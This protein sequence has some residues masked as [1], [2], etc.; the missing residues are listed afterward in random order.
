MT[1]PHP[2]ST[3][4]PNTPHFLPNASTTN[5]ARFAVINVAG[6]TPTAS[7][8]AGTAGGAFFDA[9]GNIQTTAKQSLTLG[10]GN[11]GN[12]VLTGPVKVTGF[13]TGLVHADV[14]GF[15]S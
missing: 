5:Y 14:N 2:R 9:T 10:G 6:G 1:L 12:L 8:S 15:L 11:T 4:F 13:S 3:P 7:V